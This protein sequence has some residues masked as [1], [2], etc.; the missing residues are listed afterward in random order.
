MD[1]YEPACVEDFKHRLRAYWTSEHQKD[2]W[3]RRR[4][5]RSDEAEA[6]VR[7]LVDIL[8]P[9]LEQQEQWETC[10]S[11]SQ[12]MVVIVSAAEVDIGRMRPG[13]F[14]VALPKFRTAVKVLKQKCVNHPALSLNL[15]KLLQASEGETF[16][17]DGLSAFVQALEAEGIVSCLDEAALK[18]IYDMKDEGK[19]VLVL[20]SDGRVYA[21]GIDVHVRGM[22]RSNISNPMLRMANCA[23]LSMLERTTRVQD[24]MGIEDVPMAWNIIEVNPVWGHSYIRLYYP[25]LGLD[26]RRAVFALKMNRCAMQG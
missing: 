1:P 22:D 4:E 14:Q 26:G 7:T 18:A 9:V 5:W 24:C 2:C 3:A 11:R 13:M 8:T 12:F 16:S 20:R 6:G 19:R 17:A 10:L 25:G 15:L 23:A 21:G